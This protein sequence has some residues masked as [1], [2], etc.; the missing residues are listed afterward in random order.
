MGLN[1]DSVLCTPSIGLCVEVR[2]F[3]QA[4]LRHSFHS[5]KSNLSDLCLAHCKIWGYLILVSCGDLQQRVY[6]SQLYDVNEMKCAY[7]VALKHY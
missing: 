5:T 6:Q 3:E 2:L 7:G 4:T 1:V